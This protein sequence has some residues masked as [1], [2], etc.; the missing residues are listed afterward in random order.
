MRKL[1]LSVTLLFSALIFAQVPQGIS[2]QAIALNSSGAAVVSSNVGIRLSLMDNSA[3][4]TVLYSETHTKTTSAQGLFNL[5]IG[6]GTA[7]TGTFA[8]INWAANPKFLKIEMDAA[9]GANY[10][11]VGTTQL[12]TVPYAMVA[13]S[14]ILS[15]GEG[16]VLT[17]PNGTP[18]QVSVNDAGQLSLPGSGVLGNS[19][20]S[21]YMNGSF[22]NFET[23]TALAMAIN[24]S[25]Y[26]SDI[27]GYK[28]LAAG[29][30]LKFLSSNTANAAVYGIDGAAGLALNST[31]YTVN[32][33][34][35]YYLDL[36][37]YGTEVNYTLQATSISPKVFIT[38]S[39]DGNYQFNPT[40]TIA[41]NTFTYIVNGVTGPMAF[42]FNY[43]HPFNS[44]S[45]T[46]DF[47]DNF[48]DGSVDY[49]GDPISFPGASETPKNYKITLVLNFNGSASY[50]ITQL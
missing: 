20:T 21:L 19:F 40:Y 27:Y 42:H 31:A 11:L 14:L 43:T 33:A 49:L 2:Y 30:Q 15:A 12:L 13:K 35:F 46:G 47:G 17:S 37:K 18:Y 4:G 1:L 44:S 41:T 28:Y 24:S 48:A 39:I 6:Q 34:G 25:S 10:V 50:T 23:S 3:S 26:V 32:S 9:G 8:G 7:V 29:T 5:I 22:N 16:I 36:T 45:S 38:G